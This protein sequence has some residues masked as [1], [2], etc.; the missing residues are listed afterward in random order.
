VEAPA[1][2]FNPKPIGAARCTFAEA[3][4]LCQAP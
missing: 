1:V 4:T 2:P 3:M